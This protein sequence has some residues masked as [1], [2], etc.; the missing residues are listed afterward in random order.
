MQRQTA[1]DST[2]SQAP[3]ELP[4]G[5]LKVLQLTDSHL[6][7]DPSQCLLGLNTLYT[8]D[9]VVELAF[10]TRGRPDLVLATGDLVHDAS[11]AGYKRFRKRM[12]ALQTPTYC[13]AGNHDRPDRMS[14]L[15]NR[16]G[17]HYIQHSLPQNWSL[18]FLDSTTPGETHGS[19]APDQLELLDEL[20]A[21]HPQR[22]TLIC[23][24]HQPIPVGSLWMD[25]IGLRDPEPFLQRLQHHPQIRG[26]LC[27]HIHQEF[28]GRYG[29][30]RIMGTPSTCI[31]FN[32]GQDKFGIDARPPGY[33]WLDLLPDGTIH[34][35]VD[36]LQ[37][38]P[39]GLDLAS[40]GY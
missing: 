10:R 32:A 28:E 1:N 13:L 18:I 9:Q 30:V 40:V 12:T 14:Q 3:A 26:V 27:G 6:Y 34:S 8:F 21:R 39:V 29:S 17:V 15:L 35:G 11:E 5:S 37:Q 20:L 38:M 7:A 2:T 31:Q 25:G 24:H 16:D 4:Q 33:R 19:L 23:L 36:F 22:H